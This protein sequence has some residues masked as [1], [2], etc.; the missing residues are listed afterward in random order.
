M[1]PTSLVALRKAPLS[2]AWWDLKKEIIDSCL[3][4]T[5]V[6]RVSPNELHCYSREVT[7][8]RL[9]PE[10]PHIGSPINNNKKIHWTRKVA[11]RRKRGIELG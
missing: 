5:D 8:T 3:V 10:K 2:P 7:N 4:S 1:T 9:I 11:A 6:K